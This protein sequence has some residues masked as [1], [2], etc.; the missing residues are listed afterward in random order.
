MIPGIGMAT[1]D[2]LGMIPRSRALRTLVELSVIGFSLWL[3]LP[4]SV[5]LFPQKGEISA[6]QLE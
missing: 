1:L 2:R 4:M 6:N 3:A 5:A